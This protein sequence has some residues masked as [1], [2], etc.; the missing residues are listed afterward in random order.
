MTR[1]PF[2]LLAL[3]PALALACPDDRWIG[4][5]KAQHFVGSAALAA[6]GTALTRSETAG[7]ALSV[8]L[9]IAKEAY[10]AQHSDRHCAS[11]RDL[12]AD[13]AGAYA[14]AYAAGWALVPRR[15]GFTFYLRTRF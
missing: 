14:G 15:G 1:A 5:D 3:L 11:L 6:A 8:G 2:A 13:V 7:F 12:A 9:G 4:A 10:D